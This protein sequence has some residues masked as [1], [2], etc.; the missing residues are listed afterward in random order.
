MH[1]KSLLALKRIR[2]SFKHG[3]NLDVE[4]AFVLG[5]E[6]E[7][8]LAADFFVLLHP[9]GAREIEESLLPVG[10]GLA[11][12]GGEAGPDV[13]FREFDGEEG[14]ER[15]EMVVAKGDEVERTG[16]D[17]VFG[18][19]F[20]QIEA[21]ELVHVDG[22]RARVAHVDDGLVHDGFLHDGHVEAVDLVPPRAFV[23]L[24]LAVLDA[25]DVD[26]GAVGEEEA[27]CGGRRFE[28][29]GFEFSKS[30]LPPTNDHGLSKRYRASPHIANNTPST[31][32]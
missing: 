6:G 32:R 4:I 28:F 3:G 25:G 12:S 14:H 2:S 27:V 20:V 23:L 16:E 17:G 30:N 13:A 22:E 7:R 15:G 26:G 9:D 5:G 24:A 11:D 31:P 1:N 29:D 10:V 19:D 21:D 18:F 8:E